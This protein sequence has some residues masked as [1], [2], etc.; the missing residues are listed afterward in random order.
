MAETHRV[1]SDGRSSTAH[2][3]ADE[4]A[5][6]RK[7][8]VEEAVSRLLPLDVER[9]EEPRR[10]EDVDRPVTVHLVGDPLVTEPGVA[11]G[12]LHGRTPIRWGPVEGSR[13][14]RSHA[15]CWSRLEGTPHTRLKPPTLLADE[16]RLAKVVEHHVVPL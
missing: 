13:S 15:P 14:D 4:P 6:A 11:S 7:V 9:A 16:Q 10:E 3:E 1:G 5:V 2:V 12:G 8:L